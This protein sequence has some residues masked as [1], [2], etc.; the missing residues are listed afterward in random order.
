M[1]SNQLLLHQ[2][3]GLGV[4]LDRVQIEH[5]HAEL[6]ARGLCDGGRFDQPLGHHHGNS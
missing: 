4:D 1:L 3:R 6:L 5:R 2:S